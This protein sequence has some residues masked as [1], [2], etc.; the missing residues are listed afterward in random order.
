[1]V[2]NESLRLIDWFNPSSEKL[3]H[4]DDFRV[5][6]KSDWTPR[7][8]T[9]QHG[10]TLIW[11]GESMEFLQ[12]SSTGKM[13]VERQQGWVYGG[14]RRGAKHPQPVCQYS[15]EW[16][17]GTACAVS[18]ARLERP[19]RHDVGK[20]LLIWFVLSWYVVDLHQCHAYKT[21]TEKRTKLDFFPFS[22]IRW[23][24]FLFLRRKKIFLNGKSKILTAWRENYCQHGWNFAALRTQ[25]VRD[26]SRLSDTFV[27][28]ASG[29][30]RIIQC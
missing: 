1:M 13:V 20:W 26:P 30:I 14:I 7:D 21:T 19:V 12:S 29:E 27:G 24:F 5:G 6:P 16:G 18:P 22:A 23:Q 9:V 8:N 11:W 28:G 25:S 17:Q 10:V 2:Y 15:H 4:G 3:P